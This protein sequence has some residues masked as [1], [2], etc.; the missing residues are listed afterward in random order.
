MGLRLRLSHVGE[1]CHGAAADQAN[2][3]QEQYLG[4]LHPEEVAQPGEE[5]VHEGA[6]GGVAEHG[7]GQVEEPFE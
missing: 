3:F 5:L 2:A 6:Q 1:V 4:R 7:V